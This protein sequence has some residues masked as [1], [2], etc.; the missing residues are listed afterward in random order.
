MLITACIKPK[1]M[2]TAK[3]KKKNTNGSI[4]CFSKVAS[5]MVDQYNLVHLLNVLD[6]IISSIQ[7]D[8]VAFS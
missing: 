8:L 7:F 3:K 4:R 2:D 6:Y 1:L 5:F